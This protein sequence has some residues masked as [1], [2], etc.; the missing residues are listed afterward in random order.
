MNKKIKIAIVGHGFVGKAVDYGFS[1]SN[2]EKYIIDPVIGTKLEDLIDKNID[3]SF[4]CVPTPMKDDGSIDASILFDVVE[5]LKKYTKG[6][7]AI[8]STLTPFLAKLITKNSPK[9]V[10]NPEF[11][12]EKFAT[13]DFVNPSMHVFGGRS[14]ETAELE[15]IYKNYS[16]CKP[17]KCYHMKPFEAA[18]VKYG[19]N[20]FLMTK[21]LF[22][23]QL[24]DL[25][26][27]E[28]GDYKAVSRAIASDVRIGSS[29]INSPGHDGRKG[30]GGACFPKDSVAFVVYAR[31]AN[32]PFTILEE[33]VRENQKY[34]NSYD[35]LLPREKDQNIRFDFK[36]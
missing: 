7:I 12:T 30:T 5:K 6:I 16:K 9:V 8:K 15:L 13:Q 1:D 20:N 31:E 26:E 22:F 3:V 29:H 10:C 35:D 21:V 18:F 19:I 25:V 2:C 24:C 28:G 32:K 34:R 11:L 17:C 4:V 23:N 27:K 33:V 14:Q 36:L